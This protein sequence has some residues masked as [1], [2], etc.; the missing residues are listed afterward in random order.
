MSDKIGLE[1][2]DFSIHACRYRVST[3]PV[4]NLDYLRPACYMVSGSPAE[5]RGSLMLRPAFGPVAEW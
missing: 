3:R 2:P 1:E 5:R 4:A